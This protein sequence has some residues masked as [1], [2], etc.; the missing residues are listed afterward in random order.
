[1]KIL[2]LVSYKTNNTRNF[3]NNKKQISMTPVFTS[4]D[5]AQFGTVLDSQIFNLKEIFDKEIN[6]YINQN[7]PKFTQIGKIGYDSQEKLKL[8]QNLSQQ[9][10]NKK[11]DFENQNTFKKVKKVIDPYE[12]YLSN[13]KEFEYTSKI[14]LNNEN[15]ATPEIK[16]FIKK[17]T[18]KIYQED[19]EFNKIK[20]LYE[21]YNS[22]KEELNQNLDKI[23][24][25]N[26]PDFT[27][28]LKVLDKTNRE[29]VMLILVSGY[30]DMIK[31][32]T[33]AEDLFIDYKEKN[34]PNF[35]LMERANRLYYAAQQFQEQTMNNNS[36][37]S[38]INYFLLENKN[39]ISENLTKSEISTEYNELFNKT[40]NIINLHAQKL[41]EFYKENPIKTSPRIIDKT[42][43]AQEKVNKQLNQML[44]AEKQK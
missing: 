8:A 9:L 14:I 15:Y 36:I 10:F 20:P 26:K 35:K 32:S 17:N 22:T 44:L 4:N 25:N 24:I 3:E 41:N 1:M 23:N 34:E 28:R 2:P 7:K 39:Y 12:K 19:E 30:T 13:I 40:D 38:E 5:S 16:N 18:H 33:E 37:D 6:P 43:K 29:A 27:R 11:I 42:L 21:E 31:L